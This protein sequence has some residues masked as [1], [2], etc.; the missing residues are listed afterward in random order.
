M[1]HITLE[2][3]SQAADAPRG[4]SLDPRR[5]VVKGQARPLSH[6]YEARAGSHTASPR[7]WMCC[8]CLILKKKKKRNA[9]SHVG[10][11][12]NTAISHISYTP[13][14]PPPVTA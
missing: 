8:K 11:S 12:K 1:E 6:I 4:G 9:D 10:I 2:E 5:N 14:T 3:G 13:P 7:I